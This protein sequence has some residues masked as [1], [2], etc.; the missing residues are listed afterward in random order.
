MLFEPLKVGHLTLKNRVVLPN[1]SD[2]G[3]C[4]PSGNVTQRHLD[5][6]RAIAQGGAAGRIARSLSAV[7][8]MPVVRGWQPV[9]GKEER[10]KKFTE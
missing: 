7:Q 2:F 5:H 1:I 10:T 8:G 4:T 3:L 9:S 6:S